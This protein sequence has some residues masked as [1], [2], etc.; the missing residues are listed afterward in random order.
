MTVPT[1]STT[2]PDATSNQVLN[3]LVLLVTWFGFGFTFCFG[4]LVATWLYAKL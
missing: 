4:W 3:I 1:P 2:V